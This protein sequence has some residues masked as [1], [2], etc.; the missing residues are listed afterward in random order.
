MEPGGDAGV[1]EEYKE[2][3]RR[4]LIS[5]VLDQLGREVH[6]STNCKQRPALLLV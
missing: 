3:L 4:P 6:I 1:R 2:H 5:G